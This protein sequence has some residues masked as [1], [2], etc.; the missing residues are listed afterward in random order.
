M[1]K[2]NI[3]DVCFKDDK[4]LIKGTYRVGFKHGLKLDVCNEHKD[5]CKGKTQEEIGLW[6]YKARIK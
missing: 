5:F 6:L 2:I 3:C 1:A 4:K